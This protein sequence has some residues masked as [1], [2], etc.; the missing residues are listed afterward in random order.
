MVDVAESVRLMQLDEAGVIARWRQLVEEI[1]RFELLAQG[2]RL[3]KSLGDGLLLE[4]EN[5][6]TAVQTAFGIQ[7]RVPAINAGI[8][9]E[10]AMH[11]RI[12]MH[13]ADIVVDD[14][15]IYGAG[16]NLAARLAA[17][18]R[19]G[20]IVVS[21]QVR[22][23][24]VP[25]LDGELE[26]MG[27]CWMKHL[28][29][30]VR[31]FRLGPAS[32][33]ASPWTG[34]PVRG[35]RDTVGV[36]VLP[37]EALGDAT[38]ADP[39]GHLLADD[40]IARLS[41][42][43]QL[44]VISRMSSSAFQNRQITLSAVAQALDVDYVVHGAFVRSGGSVRLQ[45]H[46]VEALQDS[47]LWSDTVRGNETALIHGDDPLIERLVEGICAAI[48]GHQVR[49]AGSSALPTLSSYTILLGAVSLLHSLSLR[50]FERSREMLAYLIE[51]HP[52]LAAPRAW[53]G[54]WHVMRVGQGWS[55]QPQV[56]ADVARSF[57]ATALDLEPTHSLSLAV[58]GLV[59]AYVHKD[60]ATAMAR[61]D[62]ALQS[63]PNEALAWLYRSACLAYR[64]QG[65]E[66]VS[67]A[68]RAQSLSPLDPM[69]YYYDNFTSTAMLA[70]GDLD[71]AVR[72]GTRSLRANRMH[73]PTLRILAI[74]HSLQGEM[75]AARQAVQ[76]MLQLEPGFSVS[77]FRARYPGQGTQQVERYARALAEAG[78]PP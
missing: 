76:E 66:A 63:N 20:E 47:V 39:L 58:D 43:A 6:P 49:R 45:V 36:A 1:R 73:G 72:Y 68:L 54:L 12:G 71:G 32:A 27:D 22:D 40:A 34:P 16:V 21:A 78:L 35:A 62:A 46:L 65:E 25:D 53:L 56:D 77:R 3:V 55:A 64:E 60:I 38:H 48:V 37:F 5:V 10:R 18:A 4:F 31:A 13:V 30:P 8:G 19:P 44:R 50:D 74:A 24:L 67:D 28:S 15:D 11:L 51:R 33:P 57:I 61:Y 52:R 41:R 42:V 29:E 26:D 14:L 2:G 70:R 17:L 75:P 59:C 23:Q 69:K 9:P 7:D